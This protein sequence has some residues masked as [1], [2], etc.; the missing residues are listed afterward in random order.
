M[1]QSAFPLGNGSGGGSMSLIASVTAAN[2]ATVSFTGLSSAFST[3]QVIIN[4]VTAGVA[5]T[6][7]FLNCSTDNG[8]TYDTTAGHY[9]WSGTGSAG[10]AT[11]NN[12]AA[13]N[14]N[15]GVAGIYLF[16][17]HG[18]DSVYTTS[19]NVYIYNPSN[20]SYINLSATASLVAPDLV[21]QWST[22]GGVYNVASGGVNAIQFS[23]SSGNIA[24]GKFN[25]YGIV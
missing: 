12:I 8:A 13:P 9:I 2:S 4:N 19:A 22:S 1:A 10:T 5:N 23:L 17:S 16:A 24:T 21:G 14:T 18:V 15:F 3:Y 25:L 11:L 20:V 6:T 7:L